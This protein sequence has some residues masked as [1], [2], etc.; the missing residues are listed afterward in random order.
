MDGA[1]TAHD[2]ETMLATGDLG[3]FRVKS[4]TKPQDKESLLA[5]QRLVREHIDGYDYLEVGS[6]LGGTLTPHLM[7]PRC[8]SVVSIDARPP[9][10][11]D[12]RGR[13]FEYENN[14]SARMIALI[15]EGA[16]EAG[17]DKLTTLDMDASQVS[18]DA[19]RN[20]PD[21]VFIDGEHTN[22]AVFRDFL[23]TYRFAQPDSVFAFHDSNLIF[24]GL[25]NIEALLGHQGV[26]HASWFLPLNVFVIAIGDW[27]ER[28]EPLL[29]AIAYE[30]EGF[31][32]ASRH[33]LWDEIAAS[34]RAA[35]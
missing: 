6:H 8:R 34:R 31:I 28:A 10:Q 1:P 14:S 27:A 16:P 17:L 33:A 2:F 21:L 22:T 15:R 25:Q 12:V 13:A 11:P 20:A 5:V 18:A 29:A 32:E 24:D 30:R 4:Q 9:S 7:D 26:V 3:L 35:E 19:L 23:N